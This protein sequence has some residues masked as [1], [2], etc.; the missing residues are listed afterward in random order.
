MGVESFAELDRL[1]SCRKEPETIDWL[2]AHLK[3]GDILYDIGANVG[4]Y[5]LVA[6]TL[7]DGGCVVYAFEPSYS[8]FGSLSRNILLNQ[9]QDRVFPFAVA[10]TS[11]TR[12]TFLE[13]SST[14]PGA[15]LHTLRGQIAPN[16]HSLPA[17]GYRLDDFAECLGLPMPN[18]IKLDVDGYELDVLL[19]SNSVLSSTSL[20][21]VLVEVD[22]ADEGSR[23]VHLHLEERGFRLASVHPHNLSS[24]ANRIYSRTTP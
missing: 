8:S 20:R 2:S 16:R 7:A 11:E 24:V 1:R 9:C 15:A 14:S 6:S 12:L 13:F 17:M 21:S 5:S 19:G 4:A 3:R 18:L 10:L 23:A 22:E